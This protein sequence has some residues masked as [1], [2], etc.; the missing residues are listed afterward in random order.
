MPSESALGIASHLD[1]CLRHWAKYLASASGFIAPYDA[2]TC[3]NIQDDPPDVHTSA[4]T[5]RLHGLD[6]KGCDTWPRVF[7]WATM[8]CRVAGGQQDRKSVV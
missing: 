1:Y 8:G 7:S 4:A 5:F 2:W 6:G 3:D